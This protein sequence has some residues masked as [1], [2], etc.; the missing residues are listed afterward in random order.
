[1]MGTNY[2]LHQKQDCECCGRAYEPLHIG[3]SSGGWCFSLH[4]MPEDG[5]NDLDDWRRLWNEPGAFIR[6]E[7]GARISLEDMEQTITQRKWKKEW[8]DGKWWSFGYTSE[9]DFHMKNYSERGPEGLLRHALGRHCL[10]HGE[11]T[12]DC[13]P[14][15]FS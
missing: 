3:K 7:Y 15:D 13:I 6:D 1:M 2:Y 10:K 8:E 12:W 5:I 11:G 4:T 14:G 9:A